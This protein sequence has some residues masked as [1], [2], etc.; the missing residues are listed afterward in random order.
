MKT[1]AGVSNGAWDGSCAKA[2]EVTLTTR[3]SWLTLVSTRELT[4]VAGSID[5]AVGIIA[6]FN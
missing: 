4:I 2:I 5:E 3:V 1:Y 6:I